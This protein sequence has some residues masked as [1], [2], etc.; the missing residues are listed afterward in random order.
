MKLIALLVV[1]AALA[2]GAD[3]LEVFNHKWTVPFASDWTIDQEDGTQVLHLNKGREPVTGP[4]RPFQFALTEVPSY[5]TLTVEADVKPTDGAMMIVFACRDA[6]HFDYAH[7][8]SDRGTEQPVHN[9]IMHVFGG[10]RVRISSQRGPAA[11]AGL[12]RWY[13]VRLVHDANTGEVVVTVDG[14]AVPALE[15]VDRSLGPGNVGLGSFDNTGAFKNLKIT[16]T[17]EYT[18]PKD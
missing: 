5:G 8:S 7:L 18:V 3:T 11:L 6:A 17:G 9:G 13:H 15:A 12:N 16:T 10:E 4:R 2:C 14:R 1:A